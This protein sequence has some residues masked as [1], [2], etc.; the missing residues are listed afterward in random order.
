[1]ISVNQSKHLSKN[2]RVQLG[3]YYTPKE[4]V[5][6]V[7]KNITPYIT[8]HRNNLTIFDNAAGSGA[9]IAKM[10][11]LNY[12]ASDCDKQACDFLQ[13]HLDKKN[14]FYTNSLIDVHR[15]KY[16]ISKQSFLIII[17]NP[18]YNDTTSEFRNGKKGKNLCD[19]DLFD[20]DLGVSFLKSYD[21]LKADVVCV[22]HPLSYL[23][24]KTNFNRLKIFKDNYTLKKGIVFPSSW[25]A[26]TGSTKFPIIIA[27]YERN[28][29]GM[30]FDYIKN[31]QFSILN[32]E[33]TFTLSLHKT[34]DGF[35]DKYPPRKNDPKTSP[36]GLYYYTFRDLNSLRRNASFLNKPHY[37]GIVVTVGN[38][39]KYAYLYALKS[40]F[41]NN[42]LWLYGNISPLIDPQDLEKNKKLYVEYALKTNKLINTLDEKVLYKIIN[43][44]KIKDKNSL[45]PRKMEQIKKSLSVLTQ[46][47]QAEYS[48]SQLLHY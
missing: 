22:L 18:P 28:E 31:F 39:Y 6:V 23:I 17:G 15:E 43:Y 21:K 20:R 42:N 14:I 7:Y 45:K 32:N 10:P 2:E 5:D 44:Y 35:I 30:D 40:L 24:K 11:N 36:L 34:T 33:K 27:L 48:Q 37:N 16:N 25:F 38:F 8:Q 19:K 46:K 1:M 3:S 13:E 47:Q 41:Q 29:N 4:L 12:R 26:K 9:F